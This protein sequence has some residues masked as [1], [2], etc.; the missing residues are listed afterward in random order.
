MDK[1]L[2]A[3]TMAET[4][5]AAIET[6]RARVTRRPAVYTGNTVGG[7]TS[8]GTVTARYGGAVIAA[9]DGEPCGLYFCGER[10]AFG[11]SPMIAA[12]PKGEGELRLDGARVGAKALALD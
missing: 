4:N 6:L 11:A 2:T 1:T 9:F 5:S 10:L 7:G 3:L 12:L 8:F